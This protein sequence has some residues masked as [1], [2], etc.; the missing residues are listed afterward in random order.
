MSRKTEKWRTPLLLCIG[1]D[2]AD[3]FDVGVRDV[4]DRRKFTLE[5]LGHAYPIDGRGQLPATDLD[6][7]RTYVGDRSPKHAGSRR[8]HARRSKCL[9]VVASARGIVAKDAAINPAQKATLMQ[10]HI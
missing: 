2:A 3:H 8:R 6:G 4:L 10:S 7:S 1:L 9:T 5:G